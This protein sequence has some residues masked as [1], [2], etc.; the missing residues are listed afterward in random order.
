MKRAKKGRGEKTAKS[1]GGELGGRV[2]PE[3]IG[4]EKPGRGGLK[5]KFR[6]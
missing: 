4:R 2:W 1:L 6:K 5:R 3:A